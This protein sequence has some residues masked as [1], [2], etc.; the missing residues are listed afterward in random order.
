MTSSVDLLV[1]IPVSVS[2]E[3]HTQSADEADGND[4]DF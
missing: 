3:H 1:L 2:S 4:V